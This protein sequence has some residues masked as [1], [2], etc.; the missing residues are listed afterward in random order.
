MSKESIPDGKIIRF[1]LKK[2][3]PVRGLIVQ[4]RDY[5][6]L[7]AKNFWRIVTQTHLAEYNKS[8]NINLAK[9]FSGTEFAKLSL[10]S[11]KAED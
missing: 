5:N 6:E 9:I 3:D 11:N 1:E 7:K 10:V 4:G 8:Q 2:R